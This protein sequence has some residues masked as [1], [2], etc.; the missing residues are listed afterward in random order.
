MNE[1]SLPSPAALGKVGVLFGGR[2]SEREIS[3]RSGNAVLRALRESGVDAHAFDPAT[4]AL[5]ELETAGFARVFLML[6]G[7]YGEDGTMQ[8]VLET[9]RIPY[10]GSGVLASAIAMDKIVTKKIWQSIGLPTP[11]WTALERGEPLPPDFAR[12]GAQLVFKPVREGSTFG[13]S[14]V[15]GA[16]RPAIEAAV[17]EALRYDRQLLVEECILGRELTCAVLGEGAGA[18]ALP[19]IEIRAPDANYDYHN[20]YFGNETQYLCPAPLDDE[21]A[22]RIQALCVLS[23]QAIGARGWARIDVMLRGEGRMA[24][25]FLLEIN[26]APGMTDHSL[27]PMAARA[28]GMEFPELVLRILAGARLEIGA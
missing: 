18:R 15:A 7:R 19:L 2:S 26:T 6:H 28:A 27:V 21:L 9:L 14:K 25:P 24:E 22:R 1:S 23:F 11:A 3:L 20:K 10:T 16:D 8:G 12:L 13:V 5:A 17:A 4:A